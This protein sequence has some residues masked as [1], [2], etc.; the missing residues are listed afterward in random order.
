VFAA[1]LNHDDSRAGNSLDMLVGEG[2]RRYIKHYMFDFGST[3]GSGT[4]EADHPWVGHEYVLEPKPGLLTLA[5][6][7]WWRR[8]FIAVKAPSSLPA[9][10]NFT[11]DGFDPARWKPHY[12]NLAYMHMQPDDAFWGAQ[13]VA[14]FSPA[15]IA[16]IVAKAQFS[17]PRVTDWVTT[18]L[19]RRRERVLHTW[20]MPFNPIVQPR[21]VGDLLVFDDA[22]ERAGLAEGSCYEAV[23][24]RFDNVTGRQVAVYGRWQRA[25]TLF[26]VPVEALGDTEFASVEL[27]IINTEHPS[28]LQP[29][30]AYFRRVGDAWTTVGVV[31]SPNDR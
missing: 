8:P 16:S 13:I 30:R 3:L 19:L 26:P 4:G 10:G 14:S 11:A 17:D 12:P 25:E 20:L 21:I 27:R 31:R 22:A 5:T 28:W 1:W 15:A 29:V 24:S 23:W 2:G 18:T 7:G 9:A 6:F